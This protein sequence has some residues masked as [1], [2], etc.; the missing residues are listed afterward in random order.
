MNL[1]ME[2]WWKIYLKAFGDFNV[3][4]SPVI[5]TNWFIGSYTT[6]E[7]CLSFKHIQP[8]DVIINVVFIAIL[9]YF[10][11]SIYSYHSI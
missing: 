6:A 5:N 3:F 9:L 7:E 2:P 8:I 4:C 10:I 1:F 11:K